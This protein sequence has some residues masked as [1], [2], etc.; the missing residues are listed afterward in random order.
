MFRNNLILVT[1]LIDQSVKFGGVQHLLH[2]RQLHLWRVNIQSKEQG[3]GRQSRLAADKTQFSLENHKVTGAGRLPQKVQRI[4]FAV[5]P[6]LTGDVEKLI[7]R[8]QILG[9]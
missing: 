4:V 7:H 2:Y 6:G 8:K 1:Y 3:R 9:D 5:D